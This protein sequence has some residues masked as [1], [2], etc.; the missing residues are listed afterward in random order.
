MANTFINICFQLCL[1]TKTYFNPTFKQNRWG[2]ERKPEHVAVQERAQYRIFFYNLGWLLVF[3]DCRNWGISLHLF[4]HL[5]P[6]VSWCQIIEES[7]TDYLVE[8]NAKCGISFNALAECVIVGHI[9]ASLKRSENFRG[10][11]GENDMGPG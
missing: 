10:A 4:K 7:L 11:S 5:V 3:W 1:K 6:P 8:I 2:I 9:F